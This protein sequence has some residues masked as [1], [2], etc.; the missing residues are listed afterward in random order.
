MGTV[1]DLASSYA[2]VDDRGSGSPR[3]AGT[4]TW[5]LA[6]ARF[7]ECTARWDADGGS[8]WVGDHQG[9][10]PTFCWSGEDDLL[11]VTYDGRN[12]HIALWD[13]Q[14]HGWR[15][16]DRD[17]SESLHYLL[18]TP[19]K[20]LANKYPDVELRKIGHGCIVGELGGSD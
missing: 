18:C 15:F 17:S 14:E 11:A 13:G 2:G 12:Y 3:P 6:E 8:D 9:P 1:N 19:R 16:Q 5:E 10:W 7:P 20:T 4:I